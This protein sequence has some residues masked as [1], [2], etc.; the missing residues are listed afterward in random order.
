MRWTLASLAGIALFMGCNSEQGF[1]P[2]GG[3]A[4]LDSDHGQWLSMAVAPTGEPA[5]AFYDRTQGALGFAVGKV[6][7]DGIEWS[8]EQADGYPDSSGLD[9]G[10]VGTYTDLVFATDGTA[11][12]S[13]ATPG[14]GTLRV[15]RRVGRTW[16]NE[17][18][19]AGSGLRPDTG[20]WTSIAMDANSQPVVVYHDEVA[21]VL[22]MAQRTGDEAWTASTIFEGEDWVGTDADGNE[23][24]RE[25]DV[26][27]YAQLIIDGNTH[28]ISF[29]DRAQREL[30]LL[31]GFAGAY[32][33]TV[34][35]SDG[36][37]GQ[38]PSMWL[39]DG[40][41]AIAYHDVGNQDLKLAVREGGG[42]FQK[43]TLDDG[44]YRGAD[45]ALFRR[46]GRWGVV[47]FDGKHND[48]VI[49]FEGGDGAFTTQTLGGAEA[50][51]GYHNEVVQDGSG[52]WWA[53]SY[54]YSKRR[55]FVKALE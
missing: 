9:G 18:V 19:D 22:R 33:K 7:A 51:V 28:Y 44:A 42:R 21:G 38:W 32:V 34:V 30:V 5:V 46:D 4:Q 12:V 36:D 27:E 35:D 39:E 10:D 37:V 31:E 29:Y 14:Q 49:A 26:G 40:N 3:Y 1:T 8:Y 16:T 48:A 41:L 53:A 45:T 52:R 50:A 24:V 2:F 25:A 47:Y 43:T 17:L 13:Y 23:I 15:A 55:L 11:W 54:D 6:R 20:R